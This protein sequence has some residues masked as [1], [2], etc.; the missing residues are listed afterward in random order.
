MVD[1]PE[2]YKLLLDS[3]KEFKDSQNWQGRSLR[4]ITPY[5]ILRTI[6]NYFGNYF[7]TTNTESLNRAFYWDRG[8]AD[9]EDVHLNEL[10][11]K[12][13]AVCAEKAATAQ[14]LL[15]FLG[16]ESVLIASTKCRLNTS[17]QDDQ[18]GH[19]YEVV[20]SGENYLI[21][22]PTNPTLVEK[23]D[24]GTYTIV[25]AFYPLGQ[26]EYK[27]LMSGG[28]VEV[29]HNDATWD[30]QKI[31]KGPDQKRIYGGPDKNTVVK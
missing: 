4:E 3:F 21:F 6:G 25:P 14:N 10:K 1:D 15:S 2:I 5:A 13:F 22:D 27:V 26:M 17:E 18:G 23:E 11:G 19:M 30:G 8:S 7:S 20:T 12:E 29:I 16:Y 28:Q 31:N 9:S 24:G